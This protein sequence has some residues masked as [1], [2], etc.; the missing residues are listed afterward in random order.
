MLSL[1]HDLLQEVTS[2]FPT[3]PLAGRL[4]TGKL[5]CANRAFKGAWVKQR[6][7]VIAYK[8]VQHYAHIYTV[9]LLSKTYFSMEEIRS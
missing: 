6:K 4:S 3:I 2:E 5:L 7:Q 9:K 1:L 8:S